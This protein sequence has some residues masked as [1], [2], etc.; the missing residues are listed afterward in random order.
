[1]ARLG[2]LLVGAGLL[3]ATQID[4]ALRAQ[5][6]WG[7]RLGTNLIELGFLDLDGLSAALAQQHRLPAALGR[8]FE[9]ADTELQQRLPP[10]LAERYSC[11]PLV[12]VGPNKEQVAVV[13]IEPLGPKAR[14]AIAHELMIQREALVNA[15]AAEL[16]VLYHLER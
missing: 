15:I 12:R 2:E 7:G 10:E 4:Q 3:T 16:R 14:T 13:S 5:V 6:V 11:V 1:M 9:K 8:H